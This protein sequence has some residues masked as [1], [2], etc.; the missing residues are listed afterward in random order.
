MNISNGVFK[1][2]LMNWDSF[3]FPVMEGTP[4][5]AAGVEANTDDAVGL[6]PQSVTEKPLIPD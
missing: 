2:V 4:V 5:S 1:S 3:T 6:L